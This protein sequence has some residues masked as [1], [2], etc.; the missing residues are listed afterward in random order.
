M[1]RIEAANKIESFGFINDFYNKFRI[2]PILRELPLFFLD[3][4][5]WLPYYLK[6]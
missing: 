4:E 3:Y 2:S 6:Q 5:Q 1:T